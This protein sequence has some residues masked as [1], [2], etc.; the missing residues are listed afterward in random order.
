MKVRGGNETIQDC[1]EKVDNAKYG[2]DPIQTNSDDVHEGLRS[3]AWLFGD[4]L[5][6][7]IPLCSRVQ[8][9]GDQNRS[10]STLDFNRGFRGPSILC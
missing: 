2:D 9:G 7:Y 6:Y 8:S 5:L 4:N 10:V 3:G 1:Q